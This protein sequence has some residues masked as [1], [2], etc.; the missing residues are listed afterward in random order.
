MDHRSYT[1]RWD[2]I[3]LDDDLHGIEE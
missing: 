1:T 2:T 3:L